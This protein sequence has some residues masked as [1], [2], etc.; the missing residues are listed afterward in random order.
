L[1]AKYFLISLIIFFFLLADGPDVPH[2]DIGRGTGAL[3][4][5]SGKS[6]LDT[7]STAPPPDSMMQACTASAT[8]NGI[9]PGGPLQVAIIG[10]GNWYITLS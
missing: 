9:A 4:R 6:L 1:S 7:T 5:H 2:A 10:S 3:V 8:L